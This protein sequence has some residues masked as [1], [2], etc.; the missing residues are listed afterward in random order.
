M[1]LTKQRSKKVQSNLSLDTASTEPRSIYADIF[2]IVRQIPRGRVTSYGAIAAYL[3]TRSGA[4]LVGWAMNASHTQ[5]PDIPAHRVVNR[6][7]VL[8]GKHHFATP[9]LMET[10]LKEEGLLIIEDTIQHFD[11]H[12]WD[13]AIALAL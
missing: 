5:A 8:T 7:G 4:R 1:K 11:H 13:P 2:D 9:D 12:F 10:R 6:N 3:G